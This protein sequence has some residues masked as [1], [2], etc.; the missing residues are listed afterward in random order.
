MYFS[1][2]TST[3]GPWLTARVPGGIYQLDCPLNTGQDTFAVGNS[4]GFSSSSPVK[5]PGHA[6]TLGR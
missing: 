3:T 6:H 4:A 2:C 5:Y 1:D